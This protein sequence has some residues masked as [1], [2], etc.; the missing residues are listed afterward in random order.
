MTDPDRSKELQDIHNQGQTD[1]SNGECHTPHSGVEQF[2]QIFNPFCSQ[3]KFEQIKEDNDAYTQGRQNDQDNH[4]C[5]L[6][7]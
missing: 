6:F 5:L 4:S 7:G 3:E 1:H 2:V